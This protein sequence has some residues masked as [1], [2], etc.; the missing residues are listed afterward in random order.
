MDNDRGENIVETQLNCPQGSDDFLS[1]IKCNIRGWDSGLLGV[2]FYSQDSLELLVG[3]A[4]HTFPVS[5]IGLLFSALSR[6]QA[7]FGLD[8]NYKEL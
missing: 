8:R 2:G 1:L 3:T 7:G 6:T 5:D 4:S